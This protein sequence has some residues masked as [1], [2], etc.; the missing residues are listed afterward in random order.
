VTLVWAAG[1]AAAVTFVR[2]ALAEAGRG[3]PTA[4]GLLF[5]VLGAGGRPAAD[6]DA[7]AGRGI[8]VLV[9][10]VLGLKGCAAFIALNSGSVAIA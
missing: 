3:T 5:V 9:S 6:V 1:I 4:T 7:L 8:A 10:G 2:A